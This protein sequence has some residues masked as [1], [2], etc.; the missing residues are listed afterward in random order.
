M[1]RYSKEPGEV[2]DLEG[3]LELERKRDHE[4]KRDYWVV[5]N[6]TED[7]EVFGHQVPNR[8]K[9]ETEMWWTSSHTDDMIL[10]QAILAAD[11]ARTALRMMLSY[12]D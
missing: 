12:T 7:V 10:G 9:G 4:L 6:G 2:V 11:S 5:T 3:D 1:K 8:K